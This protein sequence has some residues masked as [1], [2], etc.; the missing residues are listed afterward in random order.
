METHTRGHT[1]PRCGQVFPRSENLRRHLARK[2]PCIDNSNLR[3][4]QLYTAELC[5]DISYE[6]LPPTI[7]MFNSPICPFCGKTFSTVTNRNKHTRYV[8]RAAIDSKIKTTIRN[9]TVDYLHV[10]ED[11]ISSSVCNTKEDILKIINSEIR[12]LTF[13]R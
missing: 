8:C 10:L 13:T 11:K 4:S 5:T 12:R 2:N 9:T 1:C 7:E 6:P 3:N